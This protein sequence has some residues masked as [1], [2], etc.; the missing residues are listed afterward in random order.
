MIQSFIWYQFGDHSRPSTGVQKAIDTCYS[1][2]FLL[3]LL[4]KVEI[5]SICRKTYLFLFLRSI[6]SVHH[7]IVIFG[8]RYKTLCKES[9][10]WLQAPTIASLG[11]HMEDNEI[12]I[13]AGLRLG[14]LLVSPH[15]C[16]HCG[17]QVDHLAIHGLSCRKSQGRNCRHSALN[18]LLH[19]S[20]SAAGIP[21]RLE[22]E[23]TC[24]GVDDH[25][26]GI[27]IVPWKSGKP[28]AWDF[29]K[30]SPLSTTDE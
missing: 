12:R 29:P 4:K 25:P 26:D 14:V 11:L 3:Y 27:S 30:D 21:S 9:G 2:T 19:Q 24:P 20:L 7:F 10:L 22:P 18:N 1:I 15:L 13:A 6:K 23:G 17:I 5:I 8:V 16:Q 28:L